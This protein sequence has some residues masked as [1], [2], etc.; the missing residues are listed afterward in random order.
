[1]VFSNPFN[2]NRRLS[3]ILQRLG[4]RDFI[5]FANRIIM[6][7]SQFNSCHRSGVFTQ[8]FIYNFVTSCIRFL[9]YILRVIS[10]C[11]NVGEIAF[12]QSSQAYPHINQLSFSL[13]PIRLDN[14]QQ[15]MDYKCSII[16]GFAS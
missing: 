12:Q 14:V 9:C 6:I 8:G 13:F 4:F 5:K 2:Y 16:N 10:R 15:L 11:E 7:G 3:I 1:M